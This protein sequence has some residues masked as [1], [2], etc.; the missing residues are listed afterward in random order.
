MNCHQCEQ[1]NHGAGQK[2][3]LSCPKYKDIQ[4][5]SAKRKTIKCE[6]LPQALLEQFPDDRDEKGLIDGVRNLP[7]VQATIISMHYFINLPFIEIAEI[8]KMSR[9]SVSEKHSQA[10]RALRALREI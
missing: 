1:Y 7:S 10:L 3:C 9:Q 2:V 6:I 8:L 5:K 4:K